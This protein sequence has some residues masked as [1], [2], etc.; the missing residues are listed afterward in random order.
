[1]YVAFVPVRTYK[2]SNSFGIDLLSGN[3]IIPL[4]L[5]WD[6]TQSVS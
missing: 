2:S 4:I 6:H 1:M 3:D 5:Q